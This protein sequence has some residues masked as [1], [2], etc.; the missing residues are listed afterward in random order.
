MVSFCQQQSMPQVRDLAKLELLQSNEAATKF[1]LVSRRLPR[2]L[3]HTAPQRQRSL[4]C[5]HC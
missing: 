3:Q 1:I 2:N 4:R 5:C